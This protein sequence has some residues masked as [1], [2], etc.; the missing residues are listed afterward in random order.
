[1]TMTDFFF[2]FTLKGDKEEINFSKQFEYGT[3]GL[4]LL[5]DSSVLDKKLRIGCFIHLVLFP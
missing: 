2:T 3:Q 1:M 4:L 5:M